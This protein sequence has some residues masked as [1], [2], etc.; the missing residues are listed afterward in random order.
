MSSFLTVQ[1]KRPLKNGKYPIRVAVG[2]G[3][4][5][6]V[7]T[8]LSA[9]L[10]DWN[11]S[12]GVY[13]GVNARVVNNNL[14]SMLARVQDKVRELQQDGIFDSLSKTEL[15]CR[16]EGRPAKEPEQ[17]TSLLDVWQGFAAT[18]QGRTAQI[19]K[20]SLVRISSY[21]NPAEVRFDDI[22]RPWLDG[23][24][25][26]MR[27]LSGNTISLHLRNLRAVVNYAID[28]GVTTDYAFRKY[29][30]P[31]ATPNKR[32]LSVASLRKIIR[33][34][35]PPHL[36][37][38]RDFFVLSFCLCGINVADLC[39]LKEMADGRIDYTRAKTHKPYS[40]RVEP[41]AHDIISR[42]S[43]KKHLLNIL[44]TNQDYRSFYSH[45]NKAL[46]QIGVITCIG[47][48]TT[49]HARHSW[50]TIGISLDIPKETIAAGL[51]HDMGNRMTAI[52]I[53]YDMTK[54]DVANRQILDYV[55]GV[56]SQIKRK[57]RSR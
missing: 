43:G 51:G 31:K 27:G 52:Y 15:R 9:S 45:L 38:Y 26:S 48:L 16:L 17:K 8:G 56:N 36:A 34:E 33:A 19:Y 44:D 55:F 6:Y 40:V 24:V 10:G 30:I 22:N 57:K 13:V 32:A 5:L 7:A 25:A 35:L 29:K 37:K 53:D 39:G 11:E 54:V 28:C 3:K 2:Y 18:K 41:E 12:A 1:K 23:L 42:Y 46:H 49:Y 47:K 20:E 50:A 21:C 4:D 14:A